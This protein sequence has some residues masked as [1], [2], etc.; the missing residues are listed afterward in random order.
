MSKLLASPKTNSVSLKKDSTG[1]VMLI[2]SLKLKVP[3]NY[4]YVKFPERRRL[5]II[6]KVPQL[7]PSVRPP[8][9][10]RDLYMMRGPEPV[11]NKLQYGDYGIQVA[12]GGRMTHKDCE[13]VRMII[14]RQMDE[15]YMFAVWRFQQLW[16]S[17][18]RKG[19]G[20]RMGG[21][22]PSIDHYVMPVR[23]ERILM[24]V[25][26]KCEFIEV[27]P[28]LEAIQRVLPFRSRIV[29]HKSMAERVE[30]EKQLEEKNANIFTFKYCADN[31]ILG[32][33]KHLN[34]YDHMWYNKY[35]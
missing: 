34:R 11:H 1:C 3:K 26:G 35:Q 9:H 2:A 4:D 12:A 18:T 29:S 33:H 22:K 25:G 14:V 20:Q 7:E 32:C 5:K 10:M 30:K 15:R 27:K 13:A 28:M 17:V 23:A 8:K 6:D 16:Q 31:N 24:E 19:L 21:G